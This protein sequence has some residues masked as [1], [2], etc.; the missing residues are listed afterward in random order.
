[1]SQKSAQKSE[2]KPRKLSA[3]AAI[4]KIVTDGNA[5]LVEEQKKFQE[6]WEHTME[7]HVAAGGSLVLDPH[8]LDDDIKAN[9][10]AAAGN[11]F[12][13]LVFL[14]WQTVRTMA[15]IQ[16]LIQGLAAQAAGVEAPKTAEALEALNS[17]K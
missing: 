6:K 3:V 15:N 1:M 10:N 13:Q 4:E 16:L 14:Q 11:P 12:Q 9:I 17:S 7:P 2:R 5:M 8:G